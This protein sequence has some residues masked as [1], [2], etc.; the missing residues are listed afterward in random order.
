MG[1]VRTFS[2]CPIQNAKELK[3]FLPSPLLAKAFSCACER[4]CCVP[5]CLVLPN[6]KDCLIR[7]LLKLCLCQGANCD[8][9]MRAVESS[10]SRASPGPDVFLISL[11]WVLQP[12]HPPLGPDSGGGGLAAPGFFLCLP[13]PETPSSLLPSPEFLGAL[14]SISPPNLILLLPSRCPHLSR[15][16]SQTSS[17]SAR[18]SVF[19][20][21]LL[22][23]RSPRGAGAGWELESPLRSRTSSLCPRPQHRCSSRGELIP[24]T[25]K[26][27]R[28][29]F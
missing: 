27:F 29:M 20:P 12:T 14:P 10:R 6:F 1:E 28:K 4:P 18:S 11:L 13:P 8:V 26:P 22:H 25:A 3:P 24:H 9:E 23:T 16:V 17:C 2:S 15:E 19:S 5:R 21:F 7:I